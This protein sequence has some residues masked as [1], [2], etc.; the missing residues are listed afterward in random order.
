[1]SGADAGG[2]PLPWSSR[3]VHDAELNP[4][5]DA[6]V[7]RQFFVAADGRAVRDANGRFLHV[8][9]ENGK[10]TLDAEGKPVLVPVE[11]LPE[12]FDY[13]GRPILEMFPMGSS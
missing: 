13:E 7:P 12:H 6:G 1:M 4:I 8:K 5:I 2:Y 10:P 11:I 9:I 3:V